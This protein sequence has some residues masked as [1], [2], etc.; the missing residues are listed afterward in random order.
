MEA[1]PGTDQQDC[2]KCGRTIRFSDHPPDECPHC[3]IVIQKYIDSQNRKAAFEE[4]SAGK[5]AQGQAGVERKGN[6]L[7]YSVLAVGIAFIA[8]AVWFHYVKTDEQKQLSDNITSFGLILKFQEAMAKE[9]Q[10]IPNNAAFLRDKAASLQTTKNKADIENIIKQMS[11]RLEEIETKRRW[12]KW[13]SAFLGVICL[14]GF[15][16]L[17]Q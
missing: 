17:R 9:F 6:G 13:I 10:N 11:T 3:G 12:I 15:T 4:R 5:P 16:R 2:P 8:M 1:D 14:V 7:A